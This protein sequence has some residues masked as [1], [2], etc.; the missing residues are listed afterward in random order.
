[1]YSF[2]CKKREKKERERELDRQEGNK[3]VRSLKVKFL[4][5]SYKT[6]AIPYPKRFFFC[7]FTLMGLQHIQIDFSHN[8][9]RYFSVILQSIKF[10][11]IDT[12]SRRAMLK[13]DLKGALEISSEFPRLIKV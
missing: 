11:R 5:Q 13:L 3:A 8:S 6:F 2:R 7:N 4:T 12:L 1:M 9:I 10:Y